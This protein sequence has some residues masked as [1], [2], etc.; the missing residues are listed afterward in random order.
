MSAPSN[1]KFTAHSIEVRDFY[2]SN[3]AW[4]KIDKWK[5]SRTAITNR[6]LNNAWRLQSNG[7]RNEFRSLATDANSEFTLMRYTRIELIA[8]SICLFAM[9][10]TGIGAIY[11]SIWFV[12]TVLSAWLATIAY[13]LYRHHMACYLHVRMLSSQFCP[14]CGM[15]LAATKS[16][17]EL[18]APAQH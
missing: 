2:R 14:H 8:T 6:A 12:A 13:R 9:G 15:S 4:N 17:K 3:K 11:A 5:S 16:G 7:R 18:V 10:I 1:A